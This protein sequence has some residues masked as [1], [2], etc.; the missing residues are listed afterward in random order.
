MPDR[1]DYPRTVA[2]VLDPSMKFRPAA[3]RAVKRFA[4]RRP[5]AGT[6][7]ERQVKFRDLNKELA[8]AYEIP[9]PQLVFGKLDGSDSG[10]S[11]Y[12]PAMNAIILSG[13]LSVVTMLHEWGHTRG[14]GERAACRWS[15]NLFKRCFPKSF[16][17]CRFE[18][19]MLRAPNR[20]D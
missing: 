10:R 9:E 20:A 3:L 7:E 12:I 6:V 15:V 13:K 11:C 8:E 16:S 5:W 18:R 4:R 2:E 19:H 17:R 1:N 14:M